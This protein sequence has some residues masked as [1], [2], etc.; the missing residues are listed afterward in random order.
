M[1]FLVLVLEN[2]TVRTDVNVGDFEIVSDRRKVQ[3]LC[4]GIG[5]EDPPSERDFSG[6][7]NQ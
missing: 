7:V 1:H 5:E 6:C 4:R 2:D 3:F